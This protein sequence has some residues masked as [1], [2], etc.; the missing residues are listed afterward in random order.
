MKEDGFEVIEFNEKTDLM[1]VDAKCPRCSSKYLY[2]SP[3][4]QI[5]C[6]KCGITYKTDFKQDI[7]TKKA[8]QINSTI[9]YVDKLIL[10]A[11]EKYESSFITTR[12]HYIEQGCWNVSEI[13]RATEE[14]KRCTR[15]GVCIS[16]YTCRC[17]KNFKHDTNRRQQM[18][19]D[20]KSTDFVK[21]YFKEVFTNEENKEI[22]LCP[23]CKSENIR[24]TRTRNKDKC[25]LCKSDKLSNKRTNIK[26]ECTIE[27][28]KAYRI[29]NLKK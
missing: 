6:H 8:R 28:K 9:S 26:F 14:Y 7:Y 2:G 1:A 17:G 13:K 15:C 12:Q 19:P 18:C 25:H 23:H 24:M 4:V 21:T 22:R 27:R 10:R 16:C 5:P 29:E 3:Y 20:C 11:T